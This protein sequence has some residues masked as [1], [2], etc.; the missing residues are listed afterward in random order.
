M[1]DGAVTDTLLLHVANNGFKGGEIAAGISVQFNIAD[2]AG[3]GKGM[4]RSLYLNLTECF[5][6]VINW[7]VEGIG[8]IISV[9][10]SFNHAVFLP[11]NLDEA[12]AQSLGR[13]GKQSKVQ[14]C[15]LRF[16]I[17]FLSHMSDNFKTQLLRCLTLTVMT[18]GQRL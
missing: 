10:D 7:N 3:V 17:Q 18:S 14:S 9:C 4:V 6:R 8:I 11:V 13:C 15:F 2:M 1:I 5:Y 16:I 12:T